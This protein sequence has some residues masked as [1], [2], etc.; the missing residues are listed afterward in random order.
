MSDD[1]SIEVRS[2]DEGEGRSPND[3]LERDIK[4]PREPLFS[5]R[6]LVITLVVLAAFGMLYMGFREGSSGG[7]ASDNA[8][9]ELTPGPG[10][11]VL[12]QS[13]VGA[14]LKPGY[15][16]RLSINGV[17]IPEE[18]MEGALTPEALSQIPV[19]EQGRGVRPNNRNS[20]QF[21]PGPGKA[22][23]RLDTGAVDITLRYWSDE[24]GPDNARTFT[25]TIQVT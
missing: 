25:W 8:I 1:T 10:D 20:V 2:P 7:V 22:I 13:A 6:R 23:S 14:L 24:E 21:K 9:V 16:G 3:V 11:R 15:D 18:Q 5:V 17:D 19:E 4:L 12:S